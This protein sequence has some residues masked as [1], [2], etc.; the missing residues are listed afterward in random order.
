MPYV[1]IVRNEYPDV[2]SLKRVLNYAL[3]TSW[4]GGYAVNPENAFTEMLMVKTVYH[5]TEYSQLKHF[6]ITF[7]PEESRNLMYF[8]MLDIGFEIGK[9]FHEHQIAYCVHRDTSHTHIHFVMN[10]T[11]FLD[12]HQYDG[13]RHYFFGIEKILKRYLPTAKVE[14]Y[15]TEQYSELNPYTAV[16]QGVYI[17][18]C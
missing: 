18:L 6:F 2:G 3:R 8:D 10:T 5:K 4:V 16:K 14:F 7:S 11:S 13:G 17:P 9:Y 1:I 15:T 12:G